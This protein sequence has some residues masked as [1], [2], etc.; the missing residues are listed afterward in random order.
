MLCRDRGGRLSV[1]WMAAQYD[2]PSLSCWE[3]IERR[4]MA[5]TPARSDSIFFSSFENDRTFSRI[6]GEVGDCAC[7]TAL[8]SGSV[9]QAMPAARAL[10]TDRRFTAIITT[11]PGSQVAKWWGI[12]NRISASRTLRQCFASGSGRICIYRLALFHFGIAC[13]RLH[14]HRGQL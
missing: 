3:A 2:Q 8:N 11:L 6:R 14:S 13:P 5:A 4:F 10:Q 12:S 1:P 7:A 9:A